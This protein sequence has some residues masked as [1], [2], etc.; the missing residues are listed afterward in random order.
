MGGLFSNSSGKGEI[1]VTHSEL[2]AYTVML[3]AV[4]RFVY[5]ITKKH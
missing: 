3:I 2:F 5:D 1:M 4:I